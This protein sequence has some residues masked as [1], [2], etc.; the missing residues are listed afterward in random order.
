MDDNTRLALAVITL[1]GF[2]CACW[3]ARV[4]LTERSADRVRIEWARACETC[5]RIA[6][7]DVSCRKV[8][9]RAGRNRQGAK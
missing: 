7:S 2:V 5:I 4:T 8:C 9:G 6:D 1:A 3:S